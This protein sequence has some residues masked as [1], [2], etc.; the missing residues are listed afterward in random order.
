MSIWQ[1]TQKDLDVQR[2][3]AMVANCNGLD[4]LRTAGCILWDEAKRTDGSYETEYQAAVV[5]R[6]AHKA[7]TETTYWITI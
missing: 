3:Q 4:K 6:D 5:A 2:Y 1:T 7:T